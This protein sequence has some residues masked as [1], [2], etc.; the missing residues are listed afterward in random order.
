MG[1]IMNHITHYAQ[2]FPTTNQ[3]AIATVAILLK[4]KADSVIRGAQRML[5]REWDEQIITE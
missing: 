1:N 4:K 2:A 5:G 3:T